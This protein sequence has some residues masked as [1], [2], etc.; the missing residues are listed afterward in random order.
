MKYLQKT[1]AAFIVVLCLVF[2]GCSVSGKVTDFNKKSTFVS[3]IRLPEPGTLK[4]HD[5]N[6]VRE[7]RLKEI[8]TLRIQSDISKMF[9][10]ELFCLA[11]IVMKDGTAIGSFKDERAKAYV[12]VNNYLHG[13]ANDSKYRIFLNDVSKIE[14]EY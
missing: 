3:K 10:R 14:F 7:L 11:E 4:V 2:S 5:G 6:A 9:N 1:L 8:R 13:E 12:G